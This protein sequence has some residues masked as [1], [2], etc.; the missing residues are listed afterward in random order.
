MNQAITDEEFQRFRR[1]IYEAAGISMA[2]EKKVLVATRLAKRLRHHDLE[3]YGAYYR[4][5][6]S[7][8]QTG[9][10]QLVVDLLT[11]NETYFNREPQ[12]FDVLKGLLR[13]RS[14][15]QQ[16]YRIWSAAC[17]SGEEAYTLAMTLADNLNGQRWEIIGTDISSR[18]ILSC[19]RGV[20]PMSRAEKL[21][22]EL[23]HRHCKRGVRSQEGMIKVSRGLREHCSF[24]M[25]NILE[26]APELGHF[27]VIFLRNVMIYFN[28]D[29]KKRVVSNVLRNLKPGGY[30]FI[31]HSETLHGLTSELDAVAPAV[32]RSRAR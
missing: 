30:L 24:R 32:Y 12:H 9:E 22:L 17:S 13:E 29:T 8:E 15:R 11:T 31:S 26:S 27:D 2:D 5:V 21:P 18:M 3:S 1:L 25:G 10:F 16:A 4:L 28:N 6:T 7:P 14:N 23:L 19:E 20:Y